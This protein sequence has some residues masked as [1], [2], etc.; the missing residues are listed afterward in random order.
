MN[1]WPNTN[2]WPSA[3]P[4]WFQQSAHPHVYV[5]PQQQYSR[6]PANYWDQYAW[7]R[8][9]EVPAAPQFN[10]TLLILPHICSPVLH[11]PISK[12]QTTVQPST[13]TSTQSSQPIPRSSVSMSKRN[14]EV[15]SWRPLTTRIDKH[16]LPLIPSHTSD[17]SPRRS[18]GRS[19]SNH[20]RR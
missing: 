14:R 13:R 11:L 18:L 8:Q 16:S 2:S 20:P 17:F 12:S 1:P 19:T 9:N 5:P 4:A 7:N 6:P 3:P 10:G 15:R